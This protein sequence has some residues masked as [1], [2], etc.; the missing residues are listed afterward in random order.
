MKIIKL[1]I[2]SSKESVLRQTPNN[3]G[4]WGDYRF[5]VNEEVDECDY[6]VVYSKGMKKNEVTKVY[7]G[8]MIFIAGEPQ[9]VYHYANQFIENF[10]IVVAARNDIVH[11]NIIRSQPAQLWW[12]GRKIK[13]CNGV[14]SLTI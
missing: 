3:D 6:W 14:I 1:S 13:D 9:P 7:P 5:I 8:N 4:V 10:N 12:V 11:K 2:N